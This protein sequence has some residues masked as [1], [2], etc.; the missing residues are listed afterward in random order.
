MELK[1]YFQSVLRSLSTIMF[2]NI[3]SLDGLQIDVT[4]YQAYTLS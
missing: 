2:M 1:D 4:R 3:I